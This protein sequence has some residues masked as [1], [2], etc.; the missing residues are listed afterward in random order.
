M[1]SRG[2]SE[3]ARWRP[4]LKPTEAGPAKLPVTLAVHGDGTLRTR[5]DVVVGSVQHDFVEA[6]KVKPN[7]LLRF[8]ATDA[9]LDATG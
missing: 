7:D 2:W 3:R 8:T 9:Y 1:H 4:N 5:D 6:K